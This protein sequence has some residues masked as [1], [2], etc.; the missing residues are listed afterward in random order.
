[1]KKDTTNRTLKILL[2]DDFTASAKNPSIERWENEGGAAVANKP[3]WS[4][5]IPL[6]KGEIFEVKDIKVQYE[7]GRAYG[8]I[9]IE[10][11][12]L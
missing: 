3:V 12:S 1:M 9:E 2:D 7:N 6:R 8:F 5:D 11:L 4:A 10:L